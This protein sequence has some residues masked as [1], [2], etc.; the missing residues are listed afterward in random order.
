MLLLIS[1]TN[2]TRE[3]VKVEVGIKSSSKNLRCPLMTIKETLFD[4]DTK[5]LIHISKIN[6]EKEWGDFEV[7]VLSKVKRIP[8]PP[9][10]KSV[11]K[12]PNCGKENDIEQEYCEACGDPQD[13]TTPIQGPQLPL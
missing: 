10:Q 3:K 4:N 9:T 7:T 5:H 11:I 13:S 2:K 8:V 6:H 1:V 12:C